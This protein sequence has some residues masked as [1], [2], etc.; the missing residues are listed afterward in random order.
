MS[1]L[2]AGCGDGRNTWL[3][4]QLGCSVFC[5]DRDTE[6]LAL[7]REY[8]SAFASTS[9]SIQI[10]R[11][12]LDHLPYKSEQF[13]AVICSAVLHFARDRAHFEAM[14]RELVRVLK[15]GGLLWFRMTTTEG[16]AVPGVRLG[17]DLY[18]LP[19]GTVRYL[20][21]KQFLESLMAELNLVYLDPFK[22]VN[23]DNLRSMCVVCLTK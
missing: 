16:L 15:P 22:S 1:L 17:P 7:L 13:D 12:E 8:A 23:V 21:D 19:D 3:P 2:D 4:L 6:R 14:F 9:G 11:G 5:I 18:E 10:E 20:L